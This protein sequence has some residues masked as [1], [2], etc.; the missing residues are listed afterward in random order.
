L[1]RSAT[2]TVSIPLLP[3]TS[4]MILGASTLSIMTFGIMTL[5]KT[6]LFV[7]LSTTMLCHYAECHILFTVMLNAFT[8]RVVMLSVIILGVSYPTPPHFYMSS[9]R[10]FFV[11]PFQSFHFNCAP[12]LFYLARYL[13][14]SISKVHITN[15]S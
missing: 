11:T 13:Y 15:E 8:Q 7:T 12:L 1:K 2:A 3:S 10:V 9:K 14:N 6:D 5:S 4:I